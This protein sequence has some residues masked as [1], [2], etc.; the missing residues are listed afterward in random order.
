MAELDTTLSALSTP[1]RTA[2]AAA[3]DIAEDRK[4]LWFK[5]AVIYQ[6]HVKAFYDSNGDGIGDL[7]GLIE[8]LD[9]VRDLGVDTIWLLPFYP[10]PLR[11][12]GYDIADYDGIHQDYG[13]P[14]DFKELVREAHV[15]GLKVI[16][17]LVINHTSDQ[18]P[19]FQA[20][21]TAPAGS[22]E[23]DF[24]VWSDTAK[25]WEDT[26]IIFTDTE[27]SNWTWD[28][29]AGAYYWHRFFSHQPDLNFDN[30]L[31]VQAVIKVMRY[32]FDQGVD[33]MRLDAIPYLC[34]RDGTN[35]ENLPETH[36]VLKHLRA[37]LDS[38]YPDRFFLAEVNQWPEDVREYFGNGDECH[39]AYHFPLMPRIYMAV[40]EEDRH[41]IVDIM[42][43]TPEIPENCQWA[44]FLRNHDELTLEMVTARERDYMYQTYAADRRMRINVG[45]RRRLAPLMENNRRKIE[46]VNSLL[47]SVIGS[48]IVY[49]GDELGMGDNVFLGDRHGVRTPMQWSPDRNAGFS[50]AD[51]Q[52]VYLPPVMDP[53]YGYLSVNVE[54]QS[55]NTSS[56]LYWMRR[57]IAV[58]K[59]HPAFGRG[60]LRFVKPGNRKIL[61]YIREHDGEIMLCVANLSR[62]SQPVELDLKE[63]KG[64]I[65]IELLGDTAFPPIGELPYLLTLPPWGF[66]WFG[67]RLKANIPS[68]HEERP[69]PAELPTLVVPEGFAAMLGFSPSGS[70]GIQSVLAGRTLKKLREEVL[71]AFLSNQRWFAGKDRQISEVTLLD[72]RAW[73]GNNWLLALACIRYADGSSQSYNLP[74]A[75]AWEDQDYEHT[76]HILHSALARVRQRA[77]V[78]ILHDAT[79]DDD[80]CRAL[81]KGLV[82]GESQ[83]LAG[84]GVL[85]FNQTS[86]YPNVAPTSEAL[87]RR[88]AL[89]QSNT[90]VF[91]EDARRAVLKLYRGIQP[92]LAV[93]VEM[94]RFLTEMSPFKQI[95]D[96]AGWIEYETPDG[97]YTLA[98]LQRYISNQ[99]NGWDYVLGFL[100]RHLEAAMATPEG[101]TPVIDPSFL[102]LMRKLGERTGQLHAALAVTTGD[103]AFDPEP[104]GLE[105]NE[106][107]REN[108]LHDIETTL[109]L[110]AT[111]LDLLPSTARLDAERVVA[112][113]QRLREHVIRLASIPLHAVKTRHH[114]D[115]H[116]GQVLLTERDFVIVDF[117]GEPARSLEER[118]AKGSPLRDVSGMLRSFAYAGA[119]ALDKATS[120]RPQDR[121][122]LAPVIEAW[123][124]DTEHAFTESYR[125]VARQT[126]GYPQG[127][128]ADAAIDNLVALFALEKALYE[129]RYELSN[130]P[131]W[132]RIPLA[133]VA[134]LAGI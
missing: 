127:P 101:Q 24:Y 106:I 83:T 59:A 63:F 114:G 99:G 18:H 122:R 95:A 1:P 68:W 41:P 86:S 97:T 58:R 89:D 94:G 65:P 32:W 47:M 38:H 92:G 33:G 123:L 124:R 111:Q 19:W 30:P 76:Q 45:I 4:P 117:E 36:A 57:L 82:K 29:V 93:E 129:V 110:L 126:S 20:A 23:R 107:W 131:D 10:S 14:A 43:Q 31:V 2:P 40:A 118:R 53:V 70:T 80:F 91:V 132:L 125:E 64:R 51:P 120:E 67:L 17:E 115:Y 28:N 75:L 8:K 6:L 12:D 15:R 130:R 11:D 90:I 39:M 128:D 85:R 56:L 9:Y 62:S 22:P 119:V 73:Q 55:R 3:S 46:L 96:L 116:L 37:E 79:W 69:I 74:L 21:R 42:S 71:P 112:A 61:A 25:K 78:G 48:P 102:E 121:A 35:N 88:P 44:V 105:D 54:S 13:T 66:Y 27:T 134:S 52:S 50:R 49:Y 109:D 84:D 16:T 7:R 100:T 87:L 34:E 103:A 26:R 81:L 60:T 108:I 113:R 5:D 72:T 104:L 98:M 133:G 77:R